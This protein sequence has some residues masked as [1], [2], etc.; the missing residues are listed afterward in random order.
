M[1]Q[2]AN[3]WLMYAVGAL[4]GGVLF[5]LGWEIGGRIWRML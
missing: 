1:S 5:R 3:S 4:A 2:K